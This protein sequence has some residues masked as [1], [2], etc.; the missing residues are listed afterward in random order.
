MPEVLESGTSGNEGRV[1]ST[2]V[3]CKADSCGKR[4]QQV[5]ENKTSNTINS[6]KVESKTT[7]RARTAL[8]KSKSMYEQNGKESDCRQG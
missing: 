5:T 3:K 2:A 1:C 7:Q 4:S 6:Q 8:V